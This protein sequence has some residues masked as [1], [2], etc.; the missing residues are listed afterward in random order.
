MFS[1]TLWQF[2]SQDPYSVRPSIIM[3]KTSPLIH[4]ARER[5]D[6]SLDPAIIAEGKRRA[7]YSRWWGEFEQ[8]SHSTDETIEEGSTLAHIRALWCPYQK[9]RSH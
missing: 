8:E 5:N 3:A 7:N 2:G 6:G 1:V 9:V 4:Q